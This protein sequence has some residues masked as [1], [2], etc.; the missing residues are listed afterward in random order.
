M[1]I[2]FS[3]FSNVRLYLVFIIPARQLQTRGSII[4]ELVKVVGT[5]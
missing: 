1:S 3:P 5:D 2:L 4:F